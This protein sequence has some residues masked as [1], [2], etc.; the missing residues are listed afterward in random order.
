MSFARILHWLVF[1][2][3]CNKRLSCGD[4]RGILMPFWGLECRAAQREFW[5]QAFSFQRAH[6]GNIAAHRKRHFKRFIWLWFGMM[7]HACWEQKEDN[8][9]GVQCAEKP[10]SVWCLL[11]E[12][13]KYIDKQHSICIRRCCIRVQMAHSRFSL[14]LRN[15]ENEGAKRGCFK[16]HAASQPANTSQQTTQTCKKTQWYT[17]GGSKMLNDARYLRNAVLQGVG[18]VPEMMSMF[19]AMWY[20]AGVT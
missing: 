5:V 2:V 9:C 18:N 17:S 10:V 6:W 12:F 16:T 20:S 3:V 7:A 4:F 11:H 1:S 13:M 14:G 19:C 8:F 15:D